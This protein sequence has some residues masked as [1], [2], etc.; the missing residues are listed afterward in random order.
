MVF[1]YVHIKGKMIVRNEMVITTERVLN[2]S[3]EQTLLPRPMAFVVP[4]KNV[5]FVKMVHW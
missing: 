4:Y 5:D 3:C 2:F 1:I